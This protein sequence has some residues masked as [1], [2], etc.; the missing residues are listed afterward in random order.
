M[1][2]TLHMIYFKNISLTKE[3]KVQIPIDSTERTIL[4][5]SGVCVNYRLQV[6]LTIGY[7]LKICKQQQLLHII[8]IF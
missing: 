4:C 5:H 7:C 8:V 3:L 6:V 1:L 2:F